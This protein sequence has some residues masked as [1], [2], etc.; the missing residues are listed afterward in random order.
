MEQVFWV[1]NGDL[2]EVNKCLKAGGKVKLIHA[3]SE[4]VSAYGYAGG[5]SCSSNHDTVNGNIHA[6]VVVEL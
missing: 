1:C 2:Y 6:Y 3:V 5:E 4:C